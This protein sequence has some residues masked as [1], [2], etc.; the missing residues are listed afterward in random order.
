M[1]KFSY[2]E[3]VDIKQR[4][5]RVDIPKICTTPSKLKRKKIRTKNQIHKF[6][7]NKS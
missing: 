3:T 4:Q 6:R 2:K 1:S 5:I 7:Q